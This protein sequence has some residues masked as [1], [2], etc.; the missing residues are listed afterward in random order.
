MTDP[1]E[2]R[3]ARLTLQPGDV[4][5]ASIPRAQ[6]HDVV[7]DAMRTLQHIAPPRVRVL[8][9]PDDVDLSVLTRGEIEARIDGQP[10]AVP[11]AHAGNTTDSA[12]PAVR[13]DDEGRES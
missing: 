3:I 1:L 7:L 13:R 8:V 11:P 5:V 9:I 6:P 10:P 12:A 4:L 2:L